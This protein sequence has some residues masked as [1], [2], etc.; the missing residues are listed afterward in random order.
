MFKVFAFLKRNT[1]LLTHDEYRAG[2]VGYHCGQ[3][4]RLKNIRGYLVNVWSNT[5]FSDRVG[6]DLYEQITR[7]EPRDFLDWWDG[8][9][10]VFF[11]NHEAWLNAMSVEPNRATADGLVVDPDWSLADGPVLFDPVPDRPGEFKPCH[12]SMHEH[13][14]VPVERQERKSFKLMQFFKNNPNTNNEQVLA[15]YATE[16]SKLPGLN[17][18]ILNFRDSDQ[19]AA[20]RG[21]Y[22]DDTWGLSDEGIAHR[23]R[24]CAMWDGAIE[25]H[26]T[27]SNDFVSARGTLNDKLATLESAF[28]D[29]VWYVEVDENLVVMPN[30]TPPPNYYFR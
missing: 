8:F 10:E 7:N 19:A 11:D 3:S 1:A 28:F 18:C 14:L 12:L 5:S 26:F 17:G 21:F 13:I 15:E 20:M 16:V 4:R 27:H 24:F 9:P 23:A 6:T 30:R 29:S 22:G 2:H 25:F